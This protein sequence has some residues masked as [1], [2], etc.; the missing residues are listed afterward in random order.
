MIWVLCKSLR[1]GRLS[2]EPVPDRWENSEVEWGELPRVCHEHVT[3]C[4][5]GLELQTGE[6]RTRKVDRRSPY[7][8]K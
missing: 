3:E 8:L 2:F 1:K 7:L 5:C 6:H 4:T